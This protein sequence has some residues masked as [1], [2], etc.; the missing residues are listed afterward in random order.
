[1]K[2]NF[3]K[4]IQFGKKIDINVFGLGR[5]SWNC[6]GVGGRVKK[7]KLIFLKSPNSARLLMKNVWAQTFLTQSLPGPNFFKPSV[8]GD[9]RVFQAFASLFPFEWSPD[10]NIIYNIYNIQ[11]MTITYKLPQSRRKQ[12]ST[13]CF[14]LH[15]WHSWIQARLDIPSSMNV[16]WKNCSCEWALTG[17]G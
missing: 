16:L 10:R 14:P 3:L 8:P 17:N 15:V 2:I 12:N 5:I 9:L 4:I 6:L 13:D 1:M 11:Y 7:R